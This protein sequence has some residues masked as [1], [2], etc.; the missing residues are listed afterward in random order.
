[1]PREKFNYN[2]NFLVLITILYYTKEDMDKKV[3]A[4]VME[5]DWKLTG[6]L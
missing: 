4:A 5:N 2:M 6:G 1:M 3:E